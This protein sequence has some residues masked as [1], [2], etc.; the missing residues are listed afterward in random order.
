MHLPQ[1]FPPRVNF[2]IHWNMHLHVVKSHLDA[3]YS[4]VSEPREQSQECE[5]V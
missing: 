3:V 5:S 2:Y 1:Y 4:N